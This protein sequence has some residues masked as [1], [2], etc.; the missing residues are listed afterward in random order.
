MLL[1]R[2]MSPCFVVLVLFVGLSGCGGGGGTPPAVQPGAAPATTSPSEVGSRFDCDSPA[3]LP[4]MVEDVPLVALAGLWAGTLVDCRTDSR[5]TMWVY[6]AEDGRFR[7]SANDASDRRDMM[8]G[9]LAVSGDTFHALGT[10]FFED[11]WAT[12]AWLDGT[13]EGTERLDGRWSADWGGYGYFLFRR[14]RVPDRHPPIPLS[15]WPSEWVLTESDPDGVGVGAEWHIAPDG[16]VSGEDA[17]GC[18]YTGQFAA[19]IPRDFYELTLTISGCALEGDYT[20]VG[21]PQSGPFNDI[22][23]IDVDDG[24]QRS[25]SL[26]FLSN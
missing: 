13:I 10:Y 5:S 21:H 14:A 2:S 24:D 6:L 23:L 12:A 18:R 15:R 16:S 17:A 8:T 3:P 19:E 25:L 7:I 22:L 26:T 1:I 20:G 9:E 4:S 11:G